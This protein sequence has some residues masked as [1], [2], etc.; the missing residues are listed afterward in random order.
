MNKIDE[1]SFSQ[2]IKEMKQDCQAQSAEMKK[3]REEVNS[4]ARF[5]ISEPWSSRIMIGVELSI[6]VVAVVGIKYLP[7]IVPKMIE[8]LFRH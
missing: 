3:L 5:P 7:D 1:S 6:G 8:K 4:V 2:A